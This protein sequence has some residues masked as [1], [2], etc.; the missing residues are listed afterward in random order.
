MLWTVFPLLWMVGAWFVC[1]P[2]KY[3]PDLERASVASA[4]DLQRHKSAYR[5]AEEKW[6]R[7][8]LISTM[9]FWG[10]VI[11]VVTTIVLAQKNM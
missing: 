5:A 9:A 7:R 3:E 10:V 6:A 1:T 2:T 8:C 11:V 4:E